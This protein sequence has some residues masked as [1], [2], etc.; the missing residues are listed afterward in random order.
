MKILIGVDGSTGASA[1]AAFAG[2]FLDDETDPVLLYYSPP[3]LASVDLGGADEITRQRVQSSLVETVFDRAKEQLPPSARQNV[4]TLVG[5]EKAGV[6]LIEAAAEHQAD[7]IVVGAHSS[8]KFEWL[9]LGGVSRY[10]AQSSHVPVLIVRPDQRSDPTRPMRVL[11]TCD[12]RSPASCPKPFLERLAW[13]QG[14]HG[15]V[16][17]VFESYLGEIPEWL[18]ENLA[19]ESGASSAAN[20][21]MFA[22]EKHE[23]Q[24]QL[25]AWCRSLPA[26]FHCQPAELVEGHAADKICEKLKS[27]GYD[28]AVVG[29][30]HH[31]SLARLLLGSTSDA[32]LNHAP[33]SV[34]VI[35]DPR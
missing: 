5:I 18:R 24:D 6:G 19:R 20:Y 9:K 10:V 35:R 25:N 22:R 27:G 11:I 3:S 26:A 8:Q 2:R 14:T 4:V 29:A 31:N 15:E 33:C 34:L 28:L 17:S 16:M 1:A 13:P 12:R 32:V 30:H 7:L 21:D 23:A